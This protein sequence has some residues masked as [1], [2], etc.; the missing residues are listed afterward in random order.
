MRIPPLS[1][2]LVLRLNGFDEDSRFAF[3]PCIKFWPNPAAKL[4]RSVKS[5]VEARDS[6]SLRTTERGFVF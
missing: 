1:G 4:R 6:T 5:C 3:L 2:L